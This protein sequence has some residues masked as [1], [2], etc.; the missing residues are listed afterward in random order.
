MTTRTNT[1]VEA[2]AG[3]KQ[4]ISLRPT[5]LR[6]L[7]GKGAVKIIAWV[8]AL[9]GLNAFFY[10]LSAESYPGDSDK[11]STILEGQ[12]VGAGHV[13]LH[14]WTLPLDSFWTL[15]QIYY[16]VVTRLVGVRTA[17][18]HTGPAFFGALV[19]VV[20]V[21]MSREGRRGVGGLVSVL[22]LVFPTPTMSW[23]F[24][25]TGYHV[26]TLLYAWLAFIALRSGRFN[27][28]WVLGVAILAIGTLGDLLMIAYGICPA[29]LGSLVAMLR[30]RSWHAGVAGGQRPELACS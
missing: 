10:Y 21:A 22:F 11:A 16:A 5:R 3:D 23:F 2:W 7:S 6:H 20:A 14:G 9:V 8:A 15:D 25:G 29:L 19:V 1:A 28:A 18:L 17:L 12:A 13:L 27:W 26:D 30:R 4:S 24:L